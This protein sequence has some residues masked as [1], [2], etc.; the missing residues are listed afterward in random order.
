M[1]LAIAL[2]VPV[3][4]GASLLQVVVG[5]NPVTGGYSGVLYV[6]AP[7]GVLEKTVSK[8]GFIFQDYRK[9]KMLPDF[10]RT[11]ITKLLAN[12][13]I[14]AYL[15]QVEGQADGKLLL[16]QTIEGPRLSD[17]YS[18]KTATRI[19]R[20]LPDGTL[21]PD[22]ALNQECIPARAFAHGP[23]NSILASTGWEISESD[24]AFLYESG[25]K[26]LFELRPREAI[27]F[28]SPVFFSPNRTLYGFARAESGDGRRSLNLL[29]VTLEPQPKVQ[30][31]R[32]LKEVVE[33]GSNPTGRCYWIG[34]AEEFAII[35]ENS[36]S[37]ARGRSGRFLARGTV[38]S[39]PVSFE[40]IPDDVDTVLGIFSDGTAVLRQGHNALYFSSPGCI[41]NIVQEKDF[42]RAADPILAGSFHFLFSRSAVLPNDRIAFVSNRRN[43]S[44]LI[45][46][47]VGRKLISFDCGKSAS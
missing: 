38:R 47:R 6:L 17:Y 5:R 3:L 16:L 20:L 1:K 44:V 37:P 18:R 15:T 13:S 22:F 29:E 35:M 30:V 12:E 42:I 24:P 43:I 23:D 2:G 26:L 32:D 19:T 34:P 21:D 40:E 39:G 10:C 25:G 27:S 4:A 7:G 33:Y 28:G 14:E 41:P 9:T 46:D 31:V 36:A 45:T 8:L 11:E